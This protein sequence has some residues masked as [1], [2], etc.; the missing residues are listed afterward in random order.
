MMEE[1][2]RRLKVLRID[3][4]LLIHM[5]RGTFAIERDALPDDAKVVHSYVDDDYLLVNIVIESEAF[6]LVPLGE[7]IPIATGPI[8]KRFMPEDGPY[9]ERDTMP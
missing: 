8:I 3:P 7:L 4:G 1:G 5:T 2:S 6:D 9:D